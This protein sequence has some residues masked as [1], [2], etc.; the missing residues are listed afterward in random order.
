MGDGQDHAEYMSAFQEAQQ[1]IKEEAEVVQQAQQPRPFPQPQGPPEPD[2]TLPITRFLL[3]TEVQQLH[4][5]LEQWKT[6]L[7]A[8]IP[9]IDVP[10]KPGQYNE[11]NRFLTEFTG[12]LTLVARRSLALVDLIVN[13]PG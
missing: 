10:L 2:P 8:G 3:N 4:W 9:G 1:E 5:I 12:E 7:E 6:R 13:G 11:P